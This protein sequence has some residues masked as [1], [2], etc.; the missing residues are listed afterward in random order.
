MSEFIF[1]VIVDVG[2]DL[3]TNYAC[4]SL[5]VN[6]EG[7]LGKMVGSELIV[8]PPKEYVSGEMFAESILARPAT[9]IDLTKKQLLMCNTPVFSLGEILILD[10]MYGRSIPDG[11]K[12]SKWAVTYECFE[13]LEDA[14]K[15]AKEI[16]NQ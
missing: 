12:P 2:H 5:L 4:A 3:N 16:Y 1:A 15:R 6:P 14:V 8:E 10:H 13:K 11:R 9:S 7:L